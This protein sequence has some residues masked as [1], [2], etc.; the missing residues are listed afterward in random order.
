MLDFAGLR[1]FPGLFLGSPTCYLFSE[2]LTGAVS[3]FT[4]ISC[5]IPSE[6]ALSYGE[7]AGCGFTRTAESVAIM[8]QGNIKPYKQWLIWKWL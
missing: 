4:S 7:K 6:P 5:N 1:R 2:L 8:R 3:K